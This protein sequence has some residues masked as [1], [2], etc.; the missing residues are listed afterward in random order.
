MQFHRVVY[1]AAIFIMAIMDMMAITAGD[2]TVAMAKGGHDGI[3]A[4]TA[5]TNIQPRNHDC[6]L[7]K[8]P[9]WQQQ[10]P[11]HNSYYSYVAFVATTIV[12]V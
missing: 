9:S 7:A 5:T 1:L 10:L 4:I 2:T 6:Q 8:T 11:Y 12:F 3:L